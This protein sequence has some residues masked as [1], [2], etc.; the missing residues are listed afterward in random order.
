MKML[1]C[2]A[3]DAFCQMK[4]IPWR[5]PIYRQDEATVFVPD[6][7]DLDMHITAAARKQ[8]AAFLKCL[9]ETYADPSE[10]LR[11]EWKDLKGNELSINHP[12]KNHWPGN[13]E[14]SPRLIAM[15]NAM[16]HKNKRIFPTNYKTIYSSLMNLRSKAAERFQNP[17]LL[18]ISFKSFRHWGG[19]KLAYE[20]NGNQIIIMRVLRHKSWKSSLKYIH[21]KNFKLDEDFDT[22]TATTTE[23]I[24][25]LGKNG[26]Q[27]YDEITISG[28]QVHFY[29]KPKQFGGFEKQDNKTEKRVDRF[30]N[31]A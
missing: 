12:V 18:Q 2:C 17:A 16:P 8:M 22:T 20:T 4:N 13:Y 9:K 3:Y 11:C 7:K 6:E 10:I 5:R 28:I 26:W 15:L 1:A 30:L 29:R 27:K 23:E 14:L 21:N 25:E 24:L 31:A 19:S